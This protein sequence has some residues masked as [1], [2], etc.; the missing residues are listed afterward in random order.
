MLQYKKSFKGGGKSKDQNYQFQEQNPS[1]Q[2]SSKKADGLAIASLVCGIIAVVMICCCTYL[3]VILGIIAI[4]LGVMSKDEYGNKSTMAKVGVV[5][6][7]LGAVLSLLWIILAF[8]GVISIP[9]FT[10]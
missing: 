9:G 8:A 2:P 3:G 5:L 1:V 7:I 4:V 10:S 6:G